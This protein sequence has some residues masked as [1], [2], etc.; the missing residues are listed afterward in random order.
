MSCEEHPYGQVIRSLLVAYCSLLPADVGFEYL[1]PFALGFEDEFHGIAGSAFAAGVGGNVMSFFLYFGAGVFDRY[2]ETGG[3]HGGQVD[4]VVAD[5]RS[6]LGLESCFLDD[7][8]KGSLLVLN[9]LAHK[10]EF[11]IA[12]A[13]GDG[14]GD[15]LGDQPGAESANTGQRNAD[16]VVCVKTFEL[17]RF[18]GGDCGGFVSTFL[19]GGKEEQFAVGEDAVDVEEQEFDFAGAGLSGEFGHR[20]KF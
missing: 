15:T 12:G 3:A 8:F 2:G 1:L 4:D 13:E 17:D 9:A 5:K 14:G 20:E 16:A 7:F 19:T 18:L 11:Q 6:F 10:F